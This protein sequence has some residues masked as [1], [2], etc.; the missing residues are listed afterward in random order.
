MK[1]LELLTPCVSG[2]PNSELQR[3]DLNRSHRGHD[4][5]RDFG[6]HCDTQIDFTTSSR[7]SVDGAA[8]MIA[9]DIRYAQEFAM[10]N[11]VSKTITFTIDPSVYTFP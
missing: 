9:S 5:H 1:T 11:R 4:H 3:N 8:Y 6:G 7:A 2:R 10:A